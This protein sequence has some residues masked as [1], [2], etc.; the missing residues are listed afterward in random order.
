MLERGGV[1]KKLPLMLPLEMM[2]LEHRVLAREVTC[3]KLFHAA[4][5][6]LWKS[7]LEGIPGGGI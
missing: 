4:W 7:N 6:L 3:S 1:V 5:L 2:S